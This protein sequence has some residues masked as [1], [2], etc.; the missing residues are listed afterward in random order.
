MILNAGGR[1]TPPSDI[2]KRLK[3]VADFLDLKFIRNPEGTGWWA[4]TADWPATS[5]KQKFVQEGS[6][7]ADEAFDAICFLPLDCPAEQAFGYFVRAVQTFPSRPDVTGLMGRVDHYN[8]SADSPDT[9]LES[10]MEGVEKDLG[11]TRAVKGA[12]SVGGTTKKTTKKR[13]A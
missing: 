4:I 8:R 7:S 13:K 12:R 9:V 6:I 5:D 1:P 2:V 11:R 10:V 3:Q